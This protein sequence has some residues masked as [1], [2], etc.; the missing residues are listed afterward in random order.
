MISC[1][2]D[3]KEVLFAV[4]D[5]C[6]EHDALLTAVVG[7]ISSVVIAKMK[8]VLD[9]KRMLCVRRFEA[10]EKAICH[11][12]L[13]LNVY[14]NI[15]AAFESL[16][17]VES[18]IE[19][20]KSKVAILMASFQKLGEVEKD[21]V[22][23]TGVSLYTVLPTYDTKPLIRELARFCSRLQDFS[24]LANFP[25][26]LERLTQ[27]VSDF[28]VDVERILPMVEEETKHLNIIYIQLKDEVAKDDM[29]KKLFRKN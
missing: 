23:V 20:L 19:V 22:N 4:L 29:A 7:F 24:C 10:Y 26:S 8:S 13:K 6:G 16:K 3:F 21:D 27:F 11:L 28:R 1:C 12:S 25:D 17:D 14:Y 5:W 15:Q 9:I 18:P 2:C